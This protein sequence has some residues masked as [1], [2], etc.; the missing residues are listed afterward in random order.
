MLPIASVSLSASSNGI[1]G[2]TIT[3]VA[4]ITNTGHANASGLTASIILPNGT[5]QALSLPST[6]LAPQASMRATSS[7]VIPLAQLSG[8]LFARVAV[9]W[10]DGTNNSYGPVLSTASTSIAQVAVFLQNDTFTTAPAAPGPYIASTPQTFIATLT[11][12]TGVPVPG[13]TVSFNANGANTSSGSATTG[14]NGTA[15]FTYTGVNVGI[16]N[17]QASINLGAALLTTNG[18]PVSWVTPIQQLST[19]PL[20]GAFFSA[21]GSGVFNATSATPVAFTQSFPTIGFNPPTGVV[22]NNSAASIGLDAPDSLP[23]CLHGFS[24]GLFTR[25]HYVYRLQRLRLCSRYRQQRR[26]SGWSE[27][28]PASVRRDSNSRIASHGRL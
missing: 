20:I 22:P 14:A 13:I 6:S 4:T 18:V 28:K 21:D 9:T 3:Y 19:T 25:Q 23:G 17:V 12:P 7:F 15:S 5:T 1:S 10:T 26:R 27:R 16:D 24:A 11:D 2:S 8:S